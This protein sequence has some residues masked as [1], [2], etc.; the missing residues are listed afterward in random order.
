MKPTKTDYQVIVFTIFLFIAGCA[1][2]EHEE[3]IKKQDSVKVETLHD[4]LVKAQ[5]TSHAIR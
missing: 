3:A 1:V 2:K 5:D 4:S